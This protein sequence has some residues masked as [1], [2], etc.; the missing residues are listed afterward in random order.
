LPKIERIYE[1]ILPEEISVRL[2]G[3]YQIATT[4]TGAPKKR[5]EINF[6]FIPE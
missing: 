5:F 1:L 3:F 6:I 2:A 4:D